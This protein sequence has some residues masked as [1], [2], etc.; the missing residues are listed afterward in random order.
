[1]RYAA[2]SALVAASFVALAGCQKERTS[3]APASAPPAAPGDVAARLGALLSRCEKLEG[4]TEFATDKGGA[5]TVPICKL[6]GALWW[7]ADMDIDCDGGQG[8]ACKADPYYQ[9][10]TAAVDA[11][12]KPLDASTLPFVVVPKSSH[13]FDYRAQ[14]LKMGSVVAV[15]YKGNVEYGILGDVGPTGILGEA[16]YAM[17]EKLGI[18]SS[19]I[20]GGVDSGV[21]YVV[22]TGDGSVVTKKEDSAEAARIGQA[23]ALLLIGAN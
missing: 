3:V 20:S 15:L 1:M 7:T 5:A 22:F 23:R 14:G 21:T 12:G 13:G 10:E 6:E 16:S 19:P 11:R 8:A 4:T 2:V 9:S 18:P 17:A